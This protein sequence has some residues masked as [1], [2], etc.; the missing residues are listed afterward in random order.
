MTPANAIDAVSHADP[1]P[2]YDD[3]ATRPPTWDDSLGMWVVSSA[4]DVATVLGHPDARVRP[5]DAAV[6][7]ALGS[8]A[9]GDVFGR[10]VRMQDREDRASVK[11]AL[12]GALGSLDD[13]R[14][15]GAV[16][17]GASAVTRI[18]DRTGRFVDRWL[19]DVPLGAVAHLVGIDAVDLPVAVEAG[20]AV[21]ACFGP[22]P[23]ADAT[24]RAEHAVDVLTGL[25]SDAAS[26]RLGLAADLRRALPPDRGDDALANTIG[27]LFQTADATAGLCATTLVRLAEEPRPRHPDL[28]AAVANLAMH[29]PA[30]HNT[31]RWF[32]APATIDG[33]DIGAGDTVLVVLAAA[34]RD[35]RRDS[36]ESFSFGAG[37]HACPANT[38][39][40]R[41][42]ALTIGAL[43]DEWPGVL[44]DLR[45]SGCR[46]LPNARIPAFG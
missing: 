26:D 7:P 11:E 46:P 13:E 6:P 42:A 41:I 15:A 30:V 5:L 44:G 12:T 10:L 9:A 2:Y 31:R 8:T 18:D 34:N 17:A 40:P 3:L 28:A 38:L 43:L 33:V 29:D 23:P 14:V 22:V 1:S 39:A 37:A 4:A 21:A 19:A 32:A 36:N 20:R 16:W 27:L 45:V 25:V 24:A 35:R